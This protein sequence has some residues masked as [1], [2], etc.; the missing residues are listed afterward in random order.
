M[1]IYR[2]AYKTTK[3]VPPSIT[4]KPSLKVLKPKPKPQDVTRIRYRDLPDPA[5]IPNFHMHPRG[6]RRTQIPLAWLSSVDHAQFIE[7]KVRACSDV[8]P[9]M[10]KPDGSVM[11]VLSKRSQEPVQ[12]YWWH[13]GEIKKG[14]SSI[15]QGVIEFEGDTKIRLDPQRFIPLP[16]V[17]PLMKEQS[18]ERKGMWHQTLNVTHAVEITE[19]ELAQMRANIG[20]HNGEFEPNSTI[21]A[22][23][24]RLQQP[25]IWQ[26]VRD[27]Y[28]HIHR[29]L[30]T[31]RKLAEHETLTKGGT[32]MTD[33][34]A[35]TGPIDIQEAIRLYRQLGQYIAVGL[36]EN[37]HARTM[38]AT[39]MAA[40]LMYLKEAHVY[41]FK[42]IKPSAGAYPLFR[43]HDGQIHFLVGERTAVAG[44]EGKMGLVASGY[45]MEDRDEI[46]GSAALRILERDTNGVLQVPSDEYLSPAYET[47]PRVTHNYPDIINGG[48]FTST[49]SFHHHVRA[50][51]VDV[52]QADIIELERAL[53]AGVTAF[54]EEKGKQPKYGTFD[55]VTLDEMKKAEGN[56]AYPASDIEAAEL[57]MAGYAR[58]EVPVIPFSAILTKRE[59]H[60]DETPPLPVP[61]G[62]LNRD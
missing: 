42:Q 57:C 6:E 43:T 35:P 1:S 8:V 3:L 50:T 16:N 5:G 31:Q 41:P 29:H 62:E 13:G 51:V 56:L 9:F 39:D 52:T 21:L 32:T 40:I 28:Q 19:A 60:Q 27:V 55:L 2:P 54:T 22:D 33:T 15:E 59:R 24:E 47:R 48:T 26:P 45:V 7:T 11:L 46:S 18:G 38:L 25:D 12:E 49:D 10:R 44:D 23:W 37:P 4:L 30:D 14:H 34:Q 58:R 36:K 61:S 17:E 53:T 20:R